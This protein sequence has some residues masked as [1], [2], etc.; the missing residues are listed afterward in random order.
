MFNV[1]IKMLSPSLSTVWDE[2]L[3]TLNV[4]IVLKMNTALVPAVSKSAK[5][6]QEHPVLRIITQTDLITVL[7][8]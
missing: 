5:E 6:H 1:T 7:S 4:C 8:I 2:R 3:S